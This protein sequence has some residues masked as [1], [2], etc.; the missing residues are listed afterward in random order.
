MDREQ[1]DLVL[2]TDNNRNFAANPENN[3]PRDLS[4][5][6]QQR[7]SEAADQGAQEIDIEINMRTRDSK[8]SLQ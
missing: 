1:Q 2:G 8:A 3:N 4:L 6:Q 5:L 7:T